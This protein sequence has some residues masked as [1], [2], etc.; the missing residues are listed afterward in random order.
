MASNWKYRGDLNIEYGG[1][2]YNDEGPDS[3]P[4]YIEMVR[5]TPASD[6]GGPDNLF[7]IEKGSV[8]I[9]VDRPATLKSA[10]DCCGWTYDATAATLLVDGV[11]HAFQ[12]PVWREWMLDALLS[13]HGQ[14]GADSYV[15][16]VG[17]ADKDA[18][19]FLADREPDFVL[20][21]N[22][23]LKRWIEN[24]FCH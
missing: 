5:V 21:S 12:S 9:P 4:D 1:Y 10:A 22:V 19:G 2:F 6:G 15:V 14:D 18:R 24:E 13:Y 7:L 8:Y 16:R 3:M 11:E 20:R 17:K 23:K